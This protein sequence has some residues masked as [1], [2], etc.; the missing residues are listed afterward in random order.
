MAE[1]TGINLRLFAEEAY[2]SIANLSDEIGLASSS[3]YSYLRGETTPGP[4][5]LYRLAKAGC[6][7]HWLLNNEGGMFADNYAGRQHLLRIALTDRPQ[8]ERSIQEIRLIH[9]LLR[10]NDPKYDTSPD[11]FT[12]FPFDVVSE[13]E[14][15]KYASPLK[16]IIQKY[17]PRQK[18]ILGMLSPFSYGV[19]PDLHSHNTSYDLHYVHLNAHDLIPHDSDDVFVENLKFTIRTL[20]V[21]LDDLY[22]N[23]SDTI[24]I[25]TELK[26]LR[27]SN[28]IPDIDDIRDAADGH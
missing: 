17:R 28:K 16:E 12:F 15:C 14:F 18:E 1:N 5:L 25:L 3:L 8:H 23:S 7:I 27:N 19:K 2:G 6:N 26:K 24:R 4:K 21:V 22:K 9:D 10:Y 20:L 13:D 11:V